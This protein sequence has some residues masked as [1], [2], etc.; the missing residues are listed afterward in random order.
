M[1]LRA[2]VSKRATLH[3]HPALAIH[4]LTARATRYFNEHLVAS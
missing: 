2:T 1:A 4:V 3:P